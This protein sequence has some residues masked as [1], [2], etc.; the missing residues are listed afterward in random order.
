MAE[1]DGAVP[2]PDWGNRQEG[3][4]A[5]LGSDLLMRQH[6]EHSEVGGRRTWGCP[7]IRTGVMDMKGTNR[8]QLVIGWDI[9]FKD[10]GTDNQNLKISF[11][12]EIYVINLKRTSN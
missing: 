10:T 12:I 8:L 1:E 11:I 5:L 4:A 9:L 2:H 3:R 7:P 6:I